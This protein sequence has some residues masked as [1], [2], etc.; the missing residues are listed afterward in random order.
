MALKFGERKEEVLGVSGVD[1]TTAV[2]A[3]RSELY[4]GKGFGGKLLL[5]QL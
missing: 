4:S 1:D 5:F 3:E 2:G